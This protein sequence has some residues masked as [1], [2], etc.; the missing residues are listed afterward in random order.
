MEHAYKTAKLSTRVRELMEVSSLLLKRHDLCPRIC[1]SISTDE[2]FDAGTAMSVDTSA[3]GARDFSSQEL[4]DYR[5]SL[6]R[7]FQMYFSDEPPIY[8]ADW[9]PGYAV[10]VFQL[11]LN[12]DEDASRLYQNARRCLP[13]GGRMMCGEGYLPLIPGGTRRYLHALVALPGRVD[14]PNGLYVGM[15]PLGKVEPP[16][17]V[18]PVTSKEGLAGWHKV[19]RMGQHAFGETFT[20]SDGTVELPDEAQPGDR[21]YED[22]YRYWDS[23]WPEWPYRWETYYWTNVMLFGEDDPFIELRLG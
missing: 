16:T 17:K 5:N 10:V 2:D 20:R 7:Y 8:D 22:G 9:C 14:S 12:S 23:V 6:T 21:R 13:K 18:F 4:E 19:I 3:H 11:E 1:F 15:F